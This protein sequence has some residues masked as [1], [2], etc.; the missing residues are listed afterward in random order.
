MTQPTHASSDGKNGERPLI[1]ISNDDGIDA[2]GIRALV[3][4][5]DGLGELVIVAPESEQSAVGH[6]VTIRMPVRAHT[7]Q[8]EGA[9]GY[10]KAWA[11]TGTPADCVK[12][13]VNRLL[14]REPDLVVSG[15][16]QGP[17][18]AV[19]V[20]YSGTVSAASEAC[21]MGY[22]AI[23]VSNGD[24][25]ADADYEAA[26]H[27]A[28]IVASQVLERGL[29]DNV[30]L[31]VNTPD[32][33]M[34]EVKGIEVTRLARSRWIEEFSPRVDP[35]DR[36]YYWLAGRFEN[37]DDR[38]DNDLGAIDRGYVSVTP[39]ELDLTAHR[40]LAQFKAWDWT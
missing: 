40:L 16:N 18:T 13:A 4:A 35:F 31:N 3:H 14:D 28:R 5:L 6:A 38:D 32:R 27:Y 19:N 10:V 25:A 34:H 33:P 1:L 22:D 8:Y 26:G 21:I 11:V 36:P 37:L 30:L 39:L 24:W 15:I 17:N 9:S 20:L 23:A 7:V 29:P 2:H 12:L